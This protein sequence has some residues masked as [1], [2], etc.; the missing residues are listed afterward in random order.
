[1]LTHEPLLPPLLCTFDVPLETFP[2]PLLPTVLPDPLSLEPPVLELPVLEL[3]VLAAALLPLVLAAPPALLALLALLVPVVAAFA[4][5]LVCAI[6]CTSSPNPAADAA[7][8]PETTYRIFELRALRGA[9]RELRVL[10][11][12]VTMP[13]RSGGPLAVVCTTSVSRGRC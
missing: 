1:M 11:M 6:W 13:G 7:T 5:L 8:T 12:A 4:W 9:T 10:F 2:E 3:P